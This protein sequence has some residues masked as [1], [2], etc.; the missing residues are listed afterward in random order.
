M[1]FTSMLFVPYFKCISLRVQFKH[2]SLN[3]HVCTE[4]R[5]LASTLMNGTIIIKTNQD[6]D[7]F[8]PNC[9]GKETWGV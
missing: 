4:K 7:L 9:R 6:D 1:K 3:L 8:P 2:I 5:D